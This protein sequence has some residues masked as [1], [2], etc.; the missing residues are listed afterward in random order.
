MESGMRKRACQE[1][2]LEP[3]ASKANASQSPGLERARARYLHLVARCGL[4]P[5][6]ARE[7]LRRVRAQ[8]AAARAGRMRKWL[9]ALLGASS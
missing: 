4:T 6:E 9:V 8:A 7:R 2:N 5:A 1:L 3:S